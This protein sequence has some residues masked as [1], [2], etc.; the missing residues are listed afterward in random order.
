MKLEAYASSEKAKAKPK[1]QIA[2]SRHK[3]FKAS[4]TRKKKTNALRPWDQKEKG[5]SDVG[6]ASEVGRGLSRWC[7]GNLEFRRHEQGAAIT[8]R[9]RQMKGL[10][11]CDAK[12]L[13]EE[14]ALQNFKWYLSAKTIFNTQD[15]IC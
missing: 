6:S 5:V 13:K 12:V 4:R 9:P 11:G 8:K 10:G 3:Y 15:R 7:A 1:E 14:H 2:S